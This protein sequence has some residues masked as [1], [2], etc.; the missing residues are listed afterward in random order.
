MTPRYRSFCVGIDT[1]PRNPL[2]NCVHDAVDMAV[3]LEKVFG[4]SR[5]NGVAVRLLT[6][7]RADASY[8][9]ERL[10][11]FV[12]GSRPVYG[13]VFQSGHGSQCADRNGDELD[14]LDELFCPV[15]I[16]WNRRDTMLLDDDYA[17]Y[18]RRLPEGSRV[19]FISDSCHSGDLVKHIPYF[20]AAPKTIMPPADISWR[21]HQAR[22]AGLDPRQ[23]GA[24]L[25]PG[26]TAISA[27]RSDQV[28]MDG[29]PGDNENGAFTWGLLK[30]LANDPSRSLLDVVSRTR[31]LLSSHGYEQEPQIMGSALDEPH[32]C[33]VG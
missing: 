6:D 5:R 4:F 33:C 1:Y 14:G 24:D 28:A 31:N 20:N 8:I 21:N 27:C 7:N 17:S 25:P 10:D 30:V 26:V 16:D 12:S 11:W 15:D 32:P 13:T 23:L 22:E 9:H 19:I 2:K 29:N 18:F 3:L